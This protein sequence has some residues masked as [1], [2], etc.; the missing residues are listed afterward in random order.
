[1]VGFMR[2]LELVNIVSKLHRYVAIKTPHEK[3]ASSCEKVN[4]AGSTSKWPEMA[5]R[6]PTASSRG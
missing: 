5:P 4:Q 1:M 3:H 2:R 6:N